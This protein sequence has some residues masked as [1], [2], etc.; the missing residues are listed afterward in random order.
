MPNAP[1]S[2]FV[3]TNV[4]LYLRD[5]RETAK[6]AIALRWIESLEAVD[7]IVISPQV[8]NEYCNVTLNKLPLASRERL[9]DVAAGMAK[10]CTAETSAATA[11]A[12]LDLQAQ[13]HVRFYDAVL[14]A[15]ARAARCTYFLSEDLQHDRL[16]GDMR[17]LNP[18]AI[19][20][21]AILSRT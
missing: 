3:D 12:A 9:R 16:I 13:M 6:Q 17:I 19:A 20:P 1:I 14:L 7:A 21:D 18:F 4:L 11:L 15:S 8:V 2:F 10:W 5:N